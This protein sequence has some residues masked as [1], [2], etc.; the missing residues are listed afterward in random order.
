MSWLA[1]QSGNIIRD[2]CDGGDTGAE[3]VQSG[4]SIYRASRAINGDITKGSCSN[5]GETGD[6]ISYQKL[7][8][9]SNILLDK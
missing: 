3:A 4:N 6:G 8:C 7:P 5:P 9:Q 1:C 2:S